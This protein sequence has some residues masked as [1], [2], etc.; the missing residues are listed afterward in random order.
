[1]EERVPVYGFISALESGR[2]ETAVEMIIYDIHFREFLSEKGVFKRSEIPFYLGR[3]LLG[4]A[5]QMGYNLD[6]PDE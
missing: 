1:H 3:P 6:I 2:N 5:R 4:M